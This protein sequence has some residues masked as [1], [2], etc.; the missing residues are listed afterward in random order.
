[1]KVMR[2]AALAV[3]T[4]AGAAAQT[5]SQPKAF[6]RDLYEK[7]RVDSHIPLLSYSSDLARLMRVDRSRA[8]KGQV[9]KLDFDPLCSCQDPDGL[10][11]RDLK[12][13]G[14]VNDPV[15]VV[16]LR[17]PDTTEKRVTL[18]LVRAGTTWRIK[19]VATAEIPSLRAFLK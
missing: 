10:Q 3:M 17:F 16:T 8:G 2:F 18:K 6:V 12:T 11:V 7:L 9:G 1:M 4:A 19:D 14:S 5:T 13:S 15:I